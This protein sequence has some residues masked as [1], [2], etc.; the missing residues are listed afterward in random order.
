M[1]LKW[2]PLILRK[3]NKNFS[4]KLAATNIFNRTYYDAFYQTAAPFVMV[5]PG[6]TITLSVRGKF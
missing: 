2:Q 3:I 1:N 4:M 5:A 6:R